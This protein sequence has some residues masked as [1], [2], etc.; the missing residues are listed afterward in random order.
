VA[1]FNVPSPV[2]VIIEG[3]SGAIDEDL[4][5]AVARA[6]TLDRD[7]VHTEAQQFTWER[8]ARMFESWLQKIPASAYQSPGIAKAEQPA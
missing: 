6:L 2:D 8:T 3:R 5:Q 4:A 7:V 1:A